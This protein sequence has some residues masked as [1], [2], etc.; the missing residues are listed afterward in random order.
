MP[1]PAAIVAS[2]GTLP[3]AADPRHVQ[4]RRGGRRFSGNVS[5]RACSLVEAYIKTG[6]P[7]DTT[8]LVRGLLADASKDSREGSR[9]LA[10]TFAQAGP[11]L[12]QTKAFADA[13][14]LLR[15]CLAIREKTQPE[16]RDTS[17]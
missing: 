5:L 12:L 6:R 17:A 8:K 14:L 11:P 1:K 16:L 3:A 9:G 2:S 7:A 4:R 13:E 10:N 15:K